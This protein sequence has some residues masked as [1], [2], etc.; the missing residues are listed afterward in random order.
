[1][2]TLLLKRIYRSALI[3]YGINTLFP[4]VLLSVFTFLSGFMTRD[5]L[6]QMPA[7]PRVLLVIPVT[8]VLNS[9][10]AIIPVTRFKRQAA[11]GNTEWRH[12]R[13][14]SVGTYRTFVLS[15][16]VVCL[17]G[18]LNLDIFINIEFP[19]AGLFTSLW[20]ISFYLMVAF[21]LLSIVLDANE[22]LIQNVSG[23]KQIIFSLKFKI[24]FMI[25]SSFAGTVMM[26]ILISGVTAQALQMGH[27]LPL[28]IIPLFLISGGTSLV[29]MSVSLYLILNNIIGPIKTMVINFDRGASGDLTVKLPV[30]STDEIGQVSL[31][32]NH[33]FTSLKTGLSAVLDSVNRLSGSKQELGER[34]EGMASAV[35][36]IRENLNQTNM[37]MEEHSSSVLETTSAVEELARNIDSLGDH[38]QQQKNILEES[39]GSLKELMEFNG[40]LKVLSEESTKKADT[41]VEVSKEGNKRIKTMQSL[42]KN[43]LLDSEHLVE[44]NTMIDAVASQTNLLAMNA[45]IE[46]A[47]AGEAGRGFAVVADEIRKLAE[48]ASTQSKNISQNLEQVL[49]NIEN[50]GKE[51]ASVQTSFEQIDSHIHD[52]RTTVDGMHSFTETVLQF[53]NQLEDAISKLNTVSETVL[54][55]SS[56]MQIGN[57][58]ILKAVTIMRDISQQVLE[59]VREIAVGADE[60]ANQSTIMLEQNQSTDESLEQVA[61]IVK[62]YRIF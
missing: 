55:G 33:L 31:M 17:G 47:H 49:Q 1:M 28:G 27:I 38:I 58:E 29:F 9:I 15:M 53:S 11:K 7:D 23:Q 56:E 5:E 54:Q 46:A 18:I 50:V 44:A 59:A 61:E 30:T 14:L 8:L 45:A 6:M 22:A 57:T 25:I 3:I 16:L 36:Q 4:P 42:V 62:Q 39:A 19:S 2:N 20:V 32:A 35:I 40:Q 37:R 34:V 43:I 21:P 60:I 41:L 48:T 26:F 12:G 10:L 24:S 13:L 52:V 51:S